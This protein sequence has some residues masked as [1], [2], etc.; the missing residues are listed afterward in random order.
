MPRVHTPHLMMPA[1][2]AVEVLLLAVL[3]VPT[4][5]E[6]VVMVLPY[7][8]GMLVTEPKYE[9]MICRHQ[10]NQSMQVS[11]RTAM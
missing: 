8:W 11:G 6:A 2:R 9:L 5:R 10:G 4:S 3:G 7:C 1:A